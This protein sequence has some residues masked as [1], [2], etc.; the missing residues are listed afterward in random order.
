[1]SLESFGKNFN[2]IGQYIWDNFIV[3]L[4][5]AFQ[6]EDV[7]DD[8]LDLIYEKADKIETYKELFYSFLNSFPLHINKDNIFRSLMY[9]L[10]YERSKVTRGFKRDTFYL[11]FSRVFFICEVVERCKIKLEKNASAKEVE[12]YD[13]IVYSATIFF[14]SKLIEKPM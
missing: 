1:M 11:E 2:K 12:K 7:F 4:H 9:H 10:L 14:V 5:P 8:L 6:N 13:D 3:D